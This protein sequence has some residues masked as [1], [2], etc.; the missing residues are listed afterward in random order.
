MAVLEHDVVAR[1][2]PHLPSRLRA[3]RIPGRAVLRWAM[4]LAAAGLVFGTAG[5]DQHRLAP[6]PLEGSALTVLEGLAV[7]GAGTTPGGYSPAAFGTGWADV[8]GDGCDTRDE[9]LAR[10]L[11][12][13]VRADGACTVVG[14]LLQDP[15]TNH[16][17]ELDPGTL[18]AAVQVDHVVSLEDAWRSGAARWDQARRER[19][20]ADPL[21]LLAASSA[22]VAVKDARDASGWLPAST[23]YRCQYA[24]RQV[25]VKR[26]YGLSVTPAEHEAL[27]AVL[28]SCPA[29]PL[30]HR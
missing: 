2:L 11:R 22:A 3:L 10:D 20:A 12:D 21:N 1:P 15:Y 5:L 9:V 17:V 24:A 4:I 23:G 26:A 30:P 13:V 6:P 19:L 25:A 28:N 14:G 7:R 29:E 18:H 27:A 8:D 16:E